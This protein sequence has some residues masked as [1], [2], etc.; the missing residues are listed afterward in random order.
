MSSVVYLLRSPVEQIAPSLYSTGDSEAIV[1]HLNPAGS[2]PAVELAEILHPGQA[3]SL[4]AGQSLTGGQL[5]EL[6]LHAPKVITL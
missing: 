1:V 5:L 2:T 4:V 6:L 3:S